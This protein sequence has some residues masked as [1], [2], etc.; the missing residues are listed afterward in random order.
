MLVVWVTGSPARMAF[1]LVVAEAGT[2]MI[3]MITPLSARL[4][5]ATFKHTIFIRVCTLACA[6]FPHTGDIALYFPLSLSREGYLPRRCLD[7]WPCLGYGQVG[8]L[9]LVTVAL[10]GITYYE[11]WKDPSVYHTSPNSSGYQSHNVSF[12]EVWHA[13]GFHHDENCWQAPRPRW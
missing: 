4:L 7:G 3:I 8:S 11:E 5:L 10:V 6:A 1:I 9:L 2:I 12:C 13:S